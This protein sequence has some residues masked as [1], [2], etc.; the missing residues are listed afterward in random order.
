MTNDAVSKSQIFGFQSK[1]LNLA[2]TSQISGI[3]E[4]SSF[5]IRKKEKKPSSSATKRQLWNK[6]TRAKS[7]IGVDAK[8]MEVDKKK[9]AKNKLNNMQ[10]YLKI[11]QDV[12][13]TTSEQEDV[14]DEHKIAAIIDKPKSKQK[15]E[16]LTTTY[17][18]PR[19]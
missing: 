17:F 16:D 5:V 6:S 4:R 14:F 18:S 11:H 2:S 3:N 13:E 10:A 1:G 15:N 9:E 8:G 19:R 7:E 12:D